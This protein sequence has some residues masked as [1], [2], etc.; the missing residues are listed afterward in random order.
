MAAPTKIWD[1]DQ[2]EQD[3]SSTTKFLLRMNVKNKHNYLILLLTGHKEIASYNSTSGAITYGILPGSINT[4]GITVTSDGKLTAAQTG[5]AVVYAIYPV[6]AS[7]S[8]FGPAVI[9][10]VPSGSQ[11]SG[12]GQVTP[13]A[14]L[15]MTGAKPTISGTPAVNQFLTANPRKA[16]W[17]SGVTFT[18]KWFVA[19]KQVATGKQLHVAAGYRGKKVVVKVTGTKDGYTPLTKSSAA[20]TIAK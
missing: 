11:I 7:T 15:T 16:Q 17:T 14:P 18:Y 12:G 6:T 8:V 5:V 1:F 20:K 3:N 10:V 13:P 9:T 19:G 2:A 4:A